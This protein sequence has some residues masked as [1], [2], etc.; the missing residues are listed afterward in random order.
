LQKFWLE[1]IINKNVVTINGRWPNQKKHIYSFENPCFSEMEL[2]KSKKSILKKSYD[3]K[4][5]ICFVGVM[6]DWKGADVLVEAL[7]LNEQKKQI[8]MVYFIGDGD[9]KKNI[10]TVASSINDLKIKFKEFLSREDLNAIYNA[11]HILIL[12]SKSEGFPKVVAE[13]L[14]YGCV[15]VVSN[16]GS[17]DQYINENNG[18]ILVERTPKYINMAIEK[19]LSCRT[20]LKKM[21]KNG[22]KTS[23]LFTYEKYN[24]RIENIVLND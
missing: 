16:V 14:S 17:I 3:K 22:L 4:V 24:K 13:A 9:E 21:A 15:P 10:Q 20:S 2:V 11:C 5:K 23:E 7:A 18:I 12:P 6:E 1:K 19:L 8:D